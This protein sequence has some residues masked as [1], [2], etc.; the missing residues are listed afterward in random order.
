M[1]QYYFSIA[2]AVITILVCCVYFYRT[3]NKSR[4][5]IRLLDESLGRYE[6]KYKAE[7]LDKH[8]ESLATEKLIKEHKSIT[9]AYDAHLDDMEKLAELGCKEKFI[10]DVLN[11]RGVDTDKLVN[12]SRENEY[13]SKKAFR[14]NI[15][16]VSSPKALIWVA[17]I[18][19][20]LI[21]LG[22]S[23][24]IC[25]EMYDRID[26]WGL[27]RSLTMDNELIVEVVFLLLVL[28][29]IYYM[30]LFFK[31]NTYSLDI[32]DN[33]IV[34]KFITKKVIPYS[35]IKALQSIKQP[36]REVRD[37]HILR[38]ILSSKRIIRIR[39]DHLDVNQY[40]EV[41]RPRK[42][43]LEVHSD[44]DMILDFIKTKTGIKV[45][46]KRKWFFM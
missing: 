26:T 43:K 11:S 30:F 8:Y 16:I 29:F 5:R 32:E 24:L 9:D 45:E 40:D 18:Y 25:Y 38:I 44:E 39:L 7:G 3:A 37:L 42:A 23:A 17:F 15:K 13:K 33:E 36:T 21:F 46:D 34:Y 6:V 4:K 28:Y 10:I 35:E 41:I 19:F 27:K 1:K 31:I 22:G 12:E 20:E 14:K 2:F